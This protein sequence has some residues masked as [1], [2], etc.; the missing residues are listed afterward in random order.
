MDAFK[1]KFREMIYEVNGSRRT[2]IKY[3]MIISYKWHIKIFIVGKSWYFNYRV[4]PD[5]S[6]FE[7]TSRPVLFCVL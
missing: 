2:Q 7:G 1:V 4:I 6:D 3:H 5:C